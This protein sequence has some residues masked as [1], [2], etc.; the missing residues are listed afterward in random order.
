MRLLHLCALSFAAHAA[1]ATPEPD[2]ALQAR[3]VGALQNAIVTNWLRPV[4]TPVAIRCN[5]AL[6]QERGGRVRS[7]AFAEPCNADDATRRSIEAAVQRASPLPYA[8]FEAVFEAD[9]ALVFRYDGQ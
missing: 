4:T 5:V 8:G 1:A 6:H 7:V 9:V 2:P 3:Y